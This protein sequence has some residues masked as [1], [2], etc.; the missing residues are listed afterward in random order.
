MNQLGKDAAIE[1][2]A[3]L[4]QEL[5]PEWAEELEYTQVL[6][7]IYT[8]RLHEILHKIEVEDLSH[9]GRLIIGALLRYADRHRSETLRGIGQSIIDNLEINEKRLSGIE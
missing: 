6:M 2:L 1:A 5:G 7:G 4:G 9:D 8:V 3:Y